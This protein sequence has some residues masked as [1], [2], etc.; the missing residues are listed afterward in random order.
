MQIANHTFFVTGGSSGLGKATTLQLVERGANVVIADV[1][2]EGGE[3]LAKRFRDCS[4]F[5]P[6][7]VTDRSSIEHA[8]S[9]AAD[10]F[11]DL[12]GLI[13]CAG[14]LVAERMIKKDGSLC[15]PETF[16]RCLEVNLTGTFD[17]IRQITPLLANNQPNAEGERGVIVNTASIAA[18]EGQV[19]LA[20]YAASKA[21]IVGMTLPLARELGALGV[22]VMTI[23]PGVFETP[24]FKEISSERLDELERQVPFP[25]RLGKPSE[26]AALVRHIIENPMLN[27]EVIRLDGALRLP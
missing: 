10:R 22:R 27:G 26:F 23:A 20:A 14:I 19:G 8:V 17:M 21:G 7:D 3:A 15:D 25:P 12:H 5:I 24:L 2:T 18:Y 11:G 1:D 6:T 16:R 13:N 4:L 9:T